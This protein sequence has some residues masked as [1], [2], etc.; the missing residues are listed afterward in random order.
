[1]VYLGK[2]KPTISEIMDNFSCAYDQAEGSDDNPYDQLDSSEIPEETRRLV[3]DQIRK[4]GS[5]IFL[6]TV[7]GHLVKTRHTMSMTSSY[8]TQHLQKRPL[9]NNKIPRWAS[10]HGSCP[11]KEGI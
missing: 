2:E 4:A 3:H 7:S 5:N 11:K 10:H 8:Q 1:M 6:E 9:T